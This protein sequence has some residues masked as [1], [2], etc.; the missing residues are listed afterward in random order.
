MTL[1]LTP[2][3]SVRPLLVAGLVLVAV[4]AC[5]CDGV[6][7]LDEVP[8][9]PVD[10]PE[11]PPAE[12]Q[13]GVVEGR[14]C[15][16]DGDTWLG[17]ANIYVKVTN[18]DGTEGRVETFS[19]VDGRFRLEGVPVGPQ[20]LLIEKGSFAGQREVLVES[21]SVTTIPDDAC[22]L[23]TAPRIAV[24]HGSQYDNVEAVL[25]EIGVEVETIDVYEEDWAEQLLEED[26]RIN[27]YDILFLNCRSNEVT[28]AARADMK[29]RLRTFVANGGSLHASDQAYDLI[30]M[31]FPS[32]IE[33]LGND[34]ERGS[35]DEGASVDLDA[36]VL[37]DGLRGAL[38]LTAI[39]IHYG[40]STWS[41]MVG[42]S[43]DVHVYLEA[44]A[45]LLNGDVIEDAPQIV[46][47]IHGD[48]RVVYSSFHQEPGIGI[49]QEEV[50]K[51]IMFEL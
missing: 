16:P 27:D 35:A 1:S 45:P 28:Y 5:T 25:N 22:A 40:L 41:V 46:G 6:E 38:Q 49:E 29:D 3:V 21:G 18:D 11:D 39:P 20:I 48:G 19:D 43:T 12:E 44:D 17:D 37:D 47:F 10:I 13:F 24:V 26:A 4:N 36:R 51:L 31:T 2:T 7:P 8:E 32:K 15:S 14:V 33:F 23:E 50:L 30:E 42:T 9:P 34:A